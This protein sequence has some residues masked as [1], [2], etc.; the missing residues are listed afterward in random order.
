LRRW[1]GLGQNA[2]ATWLAGQDVAVEE[3][4]RGGGGGGGGRAAGSG[5]FEWAEGLKTGGGWRQEKRRGRRQRRNR[6]HTAGYAVVARGGSGD[7]SS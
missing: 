7:G 3:D 4:G 5:R 2:A 1:K 6:R